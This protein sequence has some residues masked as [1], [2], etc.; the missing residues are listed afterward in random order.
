MEKIAKELVSIAREL[1]GASYSSWER[2]V[3][4]LFK[5]TYGLDK[6]D[7]YDRTRLKNAFEDGDSPEEYVEWYGEKYDLDEI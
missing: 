7:F 5:K 2:K 3:I 1:V 6:N 4:K